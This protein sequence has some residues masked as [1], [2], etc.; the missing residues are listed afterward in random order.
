MLAVAG[1][2]LSAPAANILLRAQATHNGSVVYLGDVADVSAADEAEMQDL[3]TTPLIASPAEGTQQFLDAT[4]VRDLLASRGVDVTTLSIRGARTVEVGKAVAA[5]KIAV[6][7][8]APTPLPLVTAEESQEAVIGA[9]KQHLINAT[10]NQGWEIKVDLN[11]EEL[12]KLAPLGIELKAT[13]GRSPWTGTQRFAVARIGVPG[14]V[15]VLAHVERM[16]YVVVALRPIQQGNLVGAAD[17]ELRLQPGKLSANSAQSIDQIVGK[18]ALR[19]LKADEVVE[20]NF[21]RAPLQVQ[22]GETVKVFAR[23][24]GVTVSTYAVVQQNGSLGDLVQVQT[25]D[26]KDRFIARVS[27]WKQ[28]EVTPTG[29]SVNDITTANQPSSQRR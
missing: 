3:L 2:V 19:S 4:R 13:A 6:V 27:G 8:P 23:T 10:G 18:E 28:L 9:I 5:Q 25:L 29:A 11:S 22:R 14:S 1:S 12:A 24:A 16:S 26:K 21:V 17:V 7:Q 20:T 15:P